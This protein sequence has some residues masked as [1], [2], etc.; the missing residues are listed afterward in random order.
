MT[1]LEVAAAVAEG[2]V[3]EA[4]KVAALPT[5]RGLSY[6]LEIDARNSKWPSLLR[7]GK[8]KKKSC[9]CEESKL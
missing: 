6:R 1:A 3:V 8:K 7:I 2:Q 5:A 9:V 4:V